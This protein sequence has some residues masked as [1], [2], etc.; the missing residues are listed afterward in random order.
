MHLHPSYELRKKDWELMRVAYEGERAVKE[1]GGL[2]LPPTPAMWNKG[3]PAP[4]SVG[5]RMYDAYRKRAVFP[6]YVTSGVNTLTGLIHRKPAEIRAPERI[7]L[8]SL[9]ASGQSA[10]ALLREIN[11]DQL[12]TGRVGLLVDVP[13]GQSPADASPYI[14]L[15]EELSIINWSDDGSLVVLDESGE[16]M[17]PDTLAWEHEDRYRV[18]RL[19]PTSGQYETTTVKSD[20]F[21]DSADW[22]TPQIAGRA[23][24]RLP[25]VFCNAMDTHSDPDAPPLLG[26]GNRCMTI[27]R[28]EADYR[29]SLYMQGQE[30]LFVIGTDD[31]EADVQVGAQAV[32]HLPL[33]GDAKYVGVSAD[34]LEEQRKALEND[35][36][37]AAEMGSR[38]VSF[39]SDSDRQSGESLRVRIAAKTPT[40]SGIAETSAAALE[41]ALGIMAEWLGTAGEVSVVANTDYFEEKD[42]AQGVLELQQAKTQ[43]APISAETIHDNLRRRDLTSKTYEEELAAIEN[44]GPLIPEVE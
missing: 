9:G 32:N 38:L 39:G 22:V 26:L 7:S 34:G 11:E 1:E 16:F 5:G 28:G 8:N 6:P 41:E 23:L 4:S 10:Q 15:Y 25:F 42:A 21:L 3:Y 18:L 35:T 2:Y 19:N 43:G 36:Q 13:S 30:T 14:V 31:E 33:N 40:L 17:N 44:E 27:Y 37:L 29:Q 24:T 20:Q 12:K